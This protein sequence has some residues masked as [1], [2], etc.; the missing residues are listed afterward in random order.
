MIKCGAEKENI[1]T[2]NERHETHPIIPSPATTSVL[3]KENGTRFIGPA[4][5]VLSEIMSSSSGKI[6]SL[7]I[8]SI[9]ITKPVISTD[10]FS[11]KLAS[12]A[13]MII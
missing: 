4:S 13:L 12:S 5:G 11:V 3:R 10:G 2:A 9:L 6:S 8:K 7:L 1:I